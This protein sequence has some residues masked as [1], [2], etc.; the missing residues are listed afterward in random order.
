VGERGEDDVW[1]WVGW[2]FHA[3]FKVSGNVRRMIDG[4]E[5]PEFE[6]E[7]KAYSEIGVEIRVSM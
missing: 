6:L 4:I 5:N 3:F 1:F 7:I 2:D